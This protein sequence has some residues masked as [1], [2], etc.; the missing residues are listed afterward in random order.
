LLL[1]ASAC[2]A[3]APSSNVRLMNRFMLFPL[4]IRI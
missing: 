4:P 2:A 3:N 1:A